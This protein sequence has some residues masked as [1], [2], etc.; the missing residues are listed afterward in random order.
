[1]IKN[2][3][4]FKNDVLFKYAVCDDS[5]PDC[6]YLLR[7]MIED[8]AH[9]QCKEIHVKNPDLNPK[10]FEDADMIVDVRIVD[11]ND[12]IID[13]EMQN[14]LLTVQQRKRF[15]VYAARILADQEVPKSQ[16][17][18]TH[19]VFQII[20]IDDVDKDNLVLID[21]YQS[22]N[23]SGYIEKENLITRIYVYLPY[24]N[25]ILKEKS[26]NEFSTLE[27]AIYIFKNGI[28]NAIMNVGEKVV[29][30]MKY[31]MET[32]NQDEELRDLA[33]KR[34]LGK[35]TRNSEIKDMYD[36][37]KI[38]G[39]AEGRAEGRI[40]GSTETKYNDV[41]KLFQFQYPNADIDFLKDLTLEVYDRIFD[42]LIDRKPLEDIKEII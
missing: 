4:D 9:I 5:D 39:K 32:F 10:D 36:K 34:E 25:H 18:K 16:Y 22:R 35:R 13:I 28:D 42:M 1:M 33:Y 30:I 24:I 14:S 41:L 12:N 19:P 37:A 3:Y 21:K 6:L 40:E 11:E 26:L 20:F 29:N 2:V 15:Q 23:E 38:E 8:I 17:L 7:L 27:K 31:K